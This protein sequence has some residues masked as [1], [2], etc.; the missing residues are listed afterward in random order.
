MSAVVHDLKIAPTY[1]EAIARGRKS[2]EVRDCSDRE[3]AEDDLVVLREW[4]V[5]SDGTA[6]HTGRQLVR[7]IGYLHFVDELQL[8][9]FALLPA[10]DRI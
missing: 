6:R 4:K 3:F 2:Y 7:R 5:G 8:A 10:D 1:F 9:I